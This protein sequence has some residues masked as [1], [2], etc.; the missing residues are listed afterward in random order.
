MRLNRGKGSFPFDFYSVAQPL[1]DTF[2]RSTHPAKL[3]F[4]IFLFWKIPENVFD[5]CALQYT[6]TSKTELG[7]GFWSTF[8]K[9]C[10]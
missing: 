2:I 10:R 3:F 1:K 8:L 4:F 6:Q 7:Y 9:S 5:I